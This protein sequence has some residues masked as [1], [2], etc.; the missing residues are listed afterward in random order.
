MT[1]ERLAPDL[2]SQADTPC[3]PPRRTALSHHPVQ[4]CARDGSLITPYTNITEG[5]EAVSEAMAGLC[6]HPE[7]VRGG[8]KMPLGKLGACSFA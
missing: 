1:S 8:E 2:A 6:H 4:Q 7:E 3:P 5:G